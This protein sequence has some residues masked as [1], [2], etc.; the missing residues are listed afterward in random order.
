[1]PPPRARFL[2]IFGVALLTIGSLAAFTAG[3]TPL[4]DCTDV[5][6][7]PDQNPV[8]VDEYS[9]FD[10]GF[11]VVNNT[12]TACTT[13]ITAE[14]T[15]GVTATGETPSSVDIPANGDAG[16][17][18]HYYFASAAGLPAAH[19][20]AGTGDKARAFVFAN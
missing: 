13:T 19:L 6:I 2:G 1:M 4:P 11:N 16:A 9:A 18:G 5:T 10:L 17:T 12:S 3:G 7:T 14:G 15:G 20:V 8:Y